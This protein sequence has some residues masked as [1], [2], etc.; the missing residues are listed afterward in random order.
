[1]MKSYLYNDGV[2]S[3]SGN[4]SRRIF[5]NITAW[6]I[7]VIAVIGVA[8][9]HNFYE[10][11]FEVN[12]K[13]RTINGG[14]G[15]ASQLSRTDIDAENRQLQHGPSPRNRYSREDPLP[16]MSEL[17]RLTGDRSTG[18]T[19][20]VL[21]HGY[22]RF[23]PQFVRHLRRKP[24]RMLEIGLFY[25][26]SM[27][28]WRAYFA[29]GTVMAIDF[30]PEMCGQCDYKNDPLIMKGDQSKIEDLEAMMKLFN[31]SKSSDSKPKGVLDN[32]NSDSN[33][34]LLDL[35][36]DDGSHHPEHQKISFQYLFKHALRPGGIYIIEDI[37]M[38]YWLSGDTYKVSTRYGR[39][40]PDSLIT[41]FKAMVD[42]V[43]REYAPPSK[44][45]SS[46]F[47][48]EVD[49]WVSSVFFG[50]NCIVVR[51]HTRAEKQRFGKRP[52]RY[53]DKLLPPTS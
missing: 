18:G 41:S 21:F 39:D 10:I 32:Y 50:A 53:G 1:M 47:G 30:K 44:P 16:S 35:I 22:E 4:N 2:F 40:H 15:L 20:K 12:F 46:P 37:E 24:I 34:G 7:T 43:N 23:Y 51:K 5:R 36:V 14:S 19:D 8:F 26:E 27:R 38:N 28:M 13:P 29:K 45:F 42:V 17:A 6:A 31:I 25:G 3:K 52:Y 49:D 11:S 48:A 33:G 9:M